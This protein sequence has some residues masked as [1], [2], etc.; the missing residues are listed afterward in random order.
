MSEARPEAQAGG[1]PTLNSCCDAVQSKLDQ[2][3]LKLS[4]LEQ[5]LKTTSPQPHHEKVYG[6]VSGVL[7]AMSSVDEATMLFEG[8]PEKE[9]PEVPCKLL[10]WLDAGN[11]PDAFYKHLID[12]TIWGSQ[13]C[14]MSI[15]TSRLRAAQLYTRR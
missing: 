7:N 10:E 1:K 6:A 4:G 13:V 14:S 2:A 5:I 11:D 9:Q 15:Q 3:L 12:D 8:M